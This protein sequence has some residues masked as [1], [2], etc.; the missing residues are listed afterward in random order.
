MGEVVLPAY[1]PVLLE[2]IDAQQIFLRD[3]FAE[4][5]SAYMDKNLPADKMKAK[6]ENLVQLSSI[7]QG[8]DT[9]FG[10]PGIL[11]SLL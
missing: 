11:R 7:T 9:I 5:I 3:G 1:H 8:V 4:I 2:K 6:L 10:Y